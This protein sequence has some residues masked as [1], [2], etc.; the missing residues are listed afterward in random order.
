MVM[1]E[2]LKGFM[3]I[4]LYVYIGKEANNIDEQELDVKKA[5]EF[6]DVEEIKRNIL[7][8]P[9]KEAEILGVCRNTFQEIKKRS[10]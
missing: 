9:Q 1:F 8:M 4:L 2:F 5:Q 3:L 10:E 7:E 6:V